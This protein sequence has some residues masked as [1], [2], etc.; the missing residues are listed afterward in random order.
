[1]AQ[2]QIL[3]GPTG[4]T[5][6]QVVVALDEAARNPATQG[7]FVRLGDASLPWA[8]AEELA[9]RLEGLKASRPVVC[10]AHQ[11]GNSSLWFAARGCSQV[12]LSPAGEVSSVGIAGQVVY[13]K[14]LL[15]KLGVEA[16]FL[17][18]GKYKSA[19]ESITR[20]GPS[21]ASR[22]SLQSVLGSIRQSWLDGLVGA[23]PTEGLVS[24]AEDGPWP[25]SAAL[26]QGLVDRIGY[27]SEAREAVE[28][29][30]QVSHVRRAVKRSNEGEGLSL[31]RLLSALLGG[32]DD[33]EPKEPHVAV[34]PASGAIALRS[35]GV[36]GGDGISSESLS[37]V[38]RRLRES[39]SVKAVVLRID[40][41]GGSALASDLLWYELMQLRKKKPLIASLASTAASGGY[42][43]ASA[44]DV[45]LATRTSIVGSIGVVGGKLTIE[46]ALG[47]VGVSGVTFAAREGEGAAAR[48]AYLSP[49]MPWDEA[50]RE[51]VRTQM[52]AI[53]DLFLARVAEGRGME[54]DKVAA[55]AE[56]RIWTGQQGSERGL[57]DEIGGLGAAVALAKKRASL[58][59]DAPVEIEG[60]PD[61]LLEL[62]QG[63]EEEPIDEPAAA[64][65]RAVVL[66]RGGPLAR[67]AAPLRP[68]AAG[69]AMLLSSRESVVAAM[70]FGLSVK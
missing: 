50:T 53:Y 9:E 39:E 1:M 48:A 7:L 36:F 12:W 31:T 47:K 44:A 17:H 62:L 33:D 55:V 24:A 49:L 34:L 16:D 43:L 66:E 63:E 3:A 4:P 61:S 64:V 6:A 35:G 56:G 30:A 19:A 29:A 28:A 5:F 58:P 46:E 60:G 10:H 13:A 2:L 67:L 14:E 8:Q 65:G 27:E 37:K 20:E 52:R 57:V 15:D 23:R 38:V 18:M 22:E 70:P 59:E 68:F 40:S 32:D 51:K 54:V 69:L 45:V 26:E 21:E 11:Y 25:A 41:P 42:Y